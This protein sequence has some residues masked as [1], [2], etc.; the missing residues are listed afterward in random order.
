MTYDY[1]LY[2][3][4]GPVATIWQN[5]PQQRNAQ[6]EQML[7][8]LNDA[9]LRAGADP[10]IRAVVLSGKGGHFSAGHDLKE[11]Q[12]KRQDFTPEERWAYETRS[13]MDYCLNIYNLPKPTIAR[14]E[15]ACIAG[16]FMVANM[17]DMIVASEEA[18]FADPVLHTMAVAAV[19]V[20]VH[21]WV[22]GSRK[23]REFLFTGEPM[24]AKDALECG[25]VNRVVPAT[26]LDDAVHTLAH[27]VAQAPPFATAVLKKSLNR[28]QE[29]Q[30]FNVALSAH[31][32][33]HQLTHFS[34]EAARG[35]ADGG[36]SNSITRNKVGASVR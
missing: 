26:E 29:T 27:R 23:A 9:V 22:M 21:P 5:R 30:G 18:F 15:G 17:C 1:V 3:V 6:N 4:E 8:E 2:E 16:A 36:F 31:F 25:M 11:G 34:H 14:V 35:K 32:D 13:Y 33:A 10:E 12:I 19:E 28:T 20:L 24:P 7:D